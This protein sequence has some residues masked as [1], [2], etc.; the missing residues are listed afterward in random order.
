[1]ENTLIESSDHLAPSDELSVLS[2]SFSRSKTIKAANTQISTT[3]QTY[4][5]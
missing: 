5:R 3:F 1:M 2:S 4:L